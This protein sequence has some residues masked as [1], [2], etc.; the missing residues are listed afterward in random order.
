MEAG[1]VDCVDRL[2]ILGRFVRKELDNPLVL[3]RVRVFLVGRRQ[4]A[5][6]KQ[7]V[8]SENA[9]DAFFFFFRIA[10]MLNQSWEEFWL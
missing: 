2:R 7:L 3:R 1:K 10:S 5:S 9:V 8:K 6:Q 4:E